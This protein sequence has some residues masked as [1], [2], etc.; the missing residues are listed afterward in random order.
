MQT[1]ITHLWNSIFENTFNQNY[2][3]R[4][5]L[6]LVKLFFKMLCNKC[7]IEINVR[8][9]SITIRHMHVQ[10][11]PKICWMS[12]NLVKIEHAIQLSNLFIVSVISLK[13][14]FLPVLKRSNRDKKVLKLK[15]VFCLW[16]TFFVDCPCM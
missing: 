9:S 2:L 1:S 3:T 13:L 14:F 6:I 16:L 15:V 5:N 11:F 8:I 12:N 4:F 10:R 7:V